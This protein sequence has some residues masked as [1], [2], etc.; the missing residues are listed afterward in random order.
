VPAHEARRLQRDVVIEPDP[1]AERLGVVDERE[2]LGAG[3][4][5]R[6]Q[7]EREGEEERTQ[8]RCAERGGSSVV[9]PASQSAPLRHGPVMAN[10]TPG[11]WMFAN[12]Q[13]PFLGSNVAPAHSEP[14]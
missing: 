13:L 12:S 11:D 14:V 1:R 9:A 10:V 2:R 7:D 3:D 5:N 6:D 8:R 4:R